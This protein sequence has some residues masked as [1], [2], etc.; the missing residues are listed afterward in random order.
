MNSYRLTTL[1]SLL[2][3]GA[4][5]AGDASATITGTN[6]V[7]I[8][9]QTMPGT[10]FGKS[11]TSDL[12]AT[13]Q[14]AGTGTVVGIVADPTDPSDSHLHRIVT[15]TDRDLQYHTDSTGIYVRMFDESK[16]SL[17]S[18]DYDL[19]FVTLANRT[20]NYKIYGFANSINDPLLGV[21]SIH[22][23]DPTM[24][25]DNA[26]PEGGLIPHIAEYTLPNNGAIGTLTAAQLLAADAD[27]SNIGAFWITFEN[28]NNTPNT[29]YPELNFPGWDFRVDNIVL[30]AAVAPPAAVPIPGAV[31]LFGTGLLGL[32]AR[33]RKAAVA[34]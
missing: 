23:D 4:L 27:W 30:G 32:L 10:V 25:L 11:N 20:G 15:G 31:W 22:P 16:F 3:A 9:F 17:K 28:F 8:D 14:Q 34:A 1:S 21:G 18:F 29:H 33:G 5:F 12:T 19:S 7:T 13:Y 6:T 2:A 26:D 24:Y